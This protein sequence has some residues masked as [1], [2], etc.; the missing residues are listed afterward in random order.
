ML[1]SLLDHDYRKVANHTMINE[2]D[3]RTMATQ[4]VQDRIRRYNDKTS[5]RSSR[6]NTDERY[7]SSE[8][9]RSRRKVKV[10]ERKTDGIQILFLTILLY[11][12]IQ[13]HI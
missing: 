1:T 8:F 13:F 7:N 5:H 12:I 3:D 10:V 2:N 9:Q 6:D 4:T 11:V